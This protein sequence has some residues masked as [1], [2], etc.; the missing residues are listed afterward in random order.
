VARLTRPGSRS[1]AP[2][3]DKLELACPLLLDRFPHPGE[4]EL[5]ALV[6][7][8]LLRCRDGRISAL[9]PLFELAYPHQ[10]QIAGSLKL[11]ELDSKKR[12]CFATCVVG[13]Q[14]QVL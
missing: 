6:L 7:P 1:A 10:E 8:H 5:E 9:G 4:V 3:L 13:A 11:A 14:A 12:K 2:R